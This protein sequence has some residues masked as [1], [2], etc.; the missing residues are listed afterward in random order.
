MVAEIKEFFI[1][2]YFI[3]QISN[4]RDIYYFHFIS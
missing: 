3:L 4:R 1:S 2:C